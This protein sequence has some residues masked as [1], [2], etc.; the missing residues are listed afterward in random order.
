MAITYTALGHFILSKLR[1]SVIFFFLHP[2]RFP[3][4]FYMS[5]FD[6][7]RLTLNYLEFLDF[8][9]CLMSLRLSKSFSTDQNTTAF[10]EVAIIRHPREG[11]YAFGFITSTV[12]L[13]VCLANELLLL[14]VIFTVFLTLHS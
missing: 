4:S 1:A 8:F 9:G 6:Q 13:Q 11:E 12:T 14:S 5:V 7:E 2:P 10:K 3:L